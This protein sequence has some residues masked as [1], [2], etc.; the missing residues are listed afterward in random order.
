MGQQGEQGE[1]RGG[2]SLMGGAGGRKRGRGGPARGLQ[3]AEG[4]DGFTP[5]FQ[6]GHYYL[7]E[8]ITQPYY[9]KAAGGFWF[10]AGG[11]F[12]WDY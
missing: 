7:N 10:C 5:T 12:S 8:D 6:H 9:I 1:Q 2:I 11:K 4:D 3:S